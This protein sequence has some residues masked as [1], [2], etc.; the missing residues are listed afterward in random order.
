MF[1][2]CLELVVVIFGIIMVVEG[3]LCGVVIWCQVLG[4]VVEFVYIDMLVY[5]GILNGSYLYLDFGCNFLY[6]LKWK[7]SCLFNIEKNWNEI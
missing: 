5:V 7:N 3:G 2:F 1:I 4:V 6:L